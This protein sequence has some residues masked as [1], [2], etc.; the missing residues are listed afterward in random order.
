M[1]LKIIRCTTVCIFLSILLLFVFSSCRDEPSNSREGSVSDASQSPTHC[2]NENNEQD[3]AL[4]TKANLDKG[5][6]QKELFIERSKSDSSEGKVFK[7]EGSLEKDST[8]SFKES[9]FINEERISCAVGGGLASDT[10]S[11]IWCWSDLHIPKYNG[12][13]TTFNNGELGF[14]SECIENQI[15]KVGNEL[16]FYV[17]VKA[18]IQSWCNN[19]FNMR[20]ELLTRPW[21][22]RSPLGTEEWFGWSYRF[23]DGYKIDKKNDWVMFQVHHGISGSPPISLFINRANA[24][25]GVAGEVIVANNTLNGIKKYS[26]TGVIPLAGEKLSIVVHTIWDHVENGVLQ[27]WINGS[28]VHDSKTSTVY[29]DF[30][31]GGNAK[32]GVYAHHWRNR[33]AVQESLN[34]GI[35]NIETFIGTIR[36]ITRKSGEPLYGTDAY[37]KV[38]P[39]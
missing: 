16:R 13:T 33:N 29:P 27:V 14:D 21:E 3:F 4:E 37:K 26:T 31:W 36:M 11:K 9:V 23:G 35:S 28:L 38:V 39:D 7:K 1:V 5:I 2:H 34:Q 22:V 32:W 20:A 30:P 18:S 25:G 17:D 8:I 10:G 6:N 24:H 12:K 19:K 15:T